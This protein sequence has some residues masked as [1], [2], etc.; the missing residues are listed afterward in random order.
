MWPLIISREKPGALAPGFI[1]MV[2][3]LTLIAA[4][5]TVAAGLL[6]IPFL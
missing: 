5:V 3:G 1:L 2:R 6:L 4:V